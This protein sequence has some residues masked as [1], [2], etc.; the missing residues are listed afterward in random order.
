MTK[1]YVFG[2]EVAEEALKRRGRMEQEMRIQQ[3]HSKH[4]L[5]S[6]LARGWM[7]VETDD[8]QPIKTE[9]PQ[10]PSFDPEKYPYS[11]LEHLKKFKRG[12]ADAVAFENST[13]MEKRWEA[14]ARIRAAATLTPLEEAVHNT[15]VLSDY[16]K[17]PTARALL[18]NMSFVEIKAMLAAI[19][20][21]QMNP[22]LLPTESQPFPGQAEVAQG[23]LTA[24]NIP[25]MLNFATPA[26]GT[27]LVNANR[28]QVSALIYELQ[29]AYD[30][31]PA[32]FPENMSGVHNK[33]TFGQAETAQEET[34]KKP[35]REEKLRAQWDGMD[36]TTKTEYRIIADTYEHMCKEAK[37][38]FKNG[39]SDGLPNVNAENLRDRLNLMISKNQVKIKPRQTRTLNTIIAMHRADIIK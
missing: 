1:K 32:D 17:S 23:T 3:E 18:N 27:A 22:T 25:R 2:S 34:A 5:D 7:E 33:V 20:R 39:E 21:E 24:N 31:P 11:I 26:T 14:I 13:G 6:A 38:A 12:D 19:V 37:K 28:E 16:E 4:I 36:E 10:E 15:I 8:T 35:A 9:K 29:K 30:I